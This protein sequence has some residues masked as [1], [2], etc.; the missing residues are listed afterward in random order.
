MGLRDQITALLDRD[1]AS[2]A[3][4][5]DH[6]GVTRLLEALREA[7]ATGQITTLAARAAAHTSLDDPAD[8]CWLLGVL[9]GAGAT[10]QVCALL[11]R[12]PAAQVNLEYLSDPVVVRWLLWALQRAGATGQVAELVG[13]LPA[14]GLFEVFRMEEDQEDQYRFGREADGRPARQWAGQTS[15]E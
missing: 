11:D 6:D 7:G 10:G 9:D 5:N 1:P 4:L 2:Q 13:R 12:N 15:A 14:A 8:V 3:N